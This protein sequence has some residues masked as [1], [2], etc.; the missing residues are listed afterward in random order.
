MALVIINKLLFR[1]N[2]INFDDTRRMAL[3]F[4]KVTIIERLV[5]EV[6][7]STQLLTGPEQ[8]AVQQFS[9]FMLDLYF[10]VLCPYMWI[11]R[12]LRNSWAGWGQGRRGRSG[13]Y[14]NFV[15]KPDPREAL[16]RQGYFLKTRKFAYIMRKTDTVETIM[17]KRLKLQQ[18]KHS[19]YVINEPEDGQ[20][21]S[22]S[23]AYD[24]SR[25]GEE[26]EWGY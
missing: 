2:F 8:F 3:V 23:T 16:I 21:I 11:R 14:F 10:M 7:L 6:F 20:V 9:C 26:W 25:E 15:R 1:R 17:E 24:W 5:Y 13:K 19:V 18:H 22:M 4:L 12:S